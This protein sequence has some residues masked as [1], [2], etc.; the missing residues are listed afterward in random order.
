MGVYNHELYHLYLLLGGFDVNCFWYFVYLF[1]F[2]EI[3]LLWLG[4]FKLWYYLL[5]F[6]SF[7]ISSLDFFSCD[8]CVLYVCTFSCCTTVSDQKF[9]YIILFPS[10]VMVS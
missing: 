2:L 3:I 1:I 4:Q 9:T 5:T 6:L 7:V 8:C 10:I